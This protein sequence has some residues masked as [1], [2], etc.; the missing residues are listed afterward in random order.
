MFCR[1]C[2]QKLA[3]GDKFCS[4]CGAKTILADDNNKIEGNSQSAETAASHP[5]TENKTDVGEPLFEPFDFKSFDFGFDLDSETEKKDQLGQEE[6][7]KVVPPVEEFDWNIHTFPGMGV[8]KT[9]DIDFNWSMSPDDIPDETTAVKESEPVAE[10]QLEPEIFAPQENNWKSAEPA[11]AMSA[12]ST[13]ESEKAHASS[14]EEELFGDLDEK[15][16]EMR[17]QSE[18]IDK[19]FT[20][21]KKNEEFQKL[22]DQ[23]YEK[24]KSGNILSDEMN[25]ASVT[26][27]EKFAAR[28]PED[29]MEELFASEGVVKGYE[30][31]PVQSDVLERIEAA[32]A[33]KKAR[34]DAARLIEEEKRKAKEEA[35]RKVREEEEE[36]AKAQAAEEA[37]RRRLEEEAK[38]LA[39]ARAA[40]EAAEREM[41][42]AAARGGAVSLDDMQME[43]EKAKQAE[44]EKAKV[45]TETNA[46]V[47]TEQAIHSSEMEEARK[48]FFG[49]DDSQ[50]NVSEPEITEEGGEKPEKTKPVDKAAILAGMATASEMVQRDRAYAAAEA[51]AKAAAQ[52]DGALNQESIELPDFLGHLEDVESPQEAQVEEPLKAVESPVETSETLEEIQELQDLSEL[53]LGEDVLQPEAQELQMEEG[54]QADIGAQSAED[55]GEIPAELFSVEDLLQEDPQAEVQESAQESVT[56]ATII[57]TEDSV[58]DI[59]NNQTTAETGK[60]VSD[61]TMVFPADYNPAEDIN[62]A[63]E[64]EQKKEEMLHFA[65]AE[66]EDEDEDEKGGKGRIVLKVCL[67][68]LI[69]LLVME[70]AGVVVKIAA[71]TSGAAKFIDSQLNKVIHLFSGDED[72]EYSVFAANEEIRTKPLEDKTAL[73]KEEMDKNKDGN[74]QAIEYNKELKF[75]PDGNYENSDLRL[76]QALSDVTWYKDAENKQVYYDQAIVGTVIAY[77]SQKVNLL[78]HNDPSV[79][80]LMKTGTDLYKELKAEDGGDN[81]SI[82]T[83]QIGEIR[84]AGSS[85]FVWV[86]EEIKDSQNGNTTEKK[87]YELETAGESMKIVNSYQL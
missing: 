69:I 51:A 14:L 32:E 74:I 34:E 81:M 26:S 40:Q 53:S 33:E 5:Q 82:E 55:L 36:L 37:A 9:E 87:I 11:A 67:V 84:Q 15:T 66:D 17:K 31:K 25:T 56:D 75:D 10:T 48:A 68:I 54:T 23:E 22:L 1:N 8:E 60:K 73:I 7:K 18:E 65:D 12:A 28:K 83:L 27:E 77:D 41:E 20:F 24:I 35:E 85:Y 78:N 80:N 42:R 79:L 76:T 57:M 61:E 43:A 64:E 2:G 49:Q 59:L 13:V 44:E 30:P 16:D 45:Q 63:I 52:A 46:E 4:S 71:P 70:I 62:E 47:P 50:K 6:V 58:G 29:P 19:F 72:T 38:R 39:D 86:S 21:H 3:D